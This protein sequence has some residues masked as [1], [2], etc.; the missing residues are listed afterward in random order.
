MSAAIDSKDVLPPQVD[1][2][3]NPAAVAV[4]PPAQEQPAAPEKT[5]PAPYVDPREEIAQRFQARRREVDGA[6]QFDAAYTPP[7]TVD[8]PQPD[9]GPAAQQQPAA[10]PAAAAPAAERFTV[11][12]NRNDVDLSWDEVAKASE[13]E[14][15]ELATLPRSAVLGLARKNL[16][17]LAYLDEAKQ[18][19]KQTRLPT[20]SPAPGEDGN[21]DQPAGD[22]QGAQGDDVDPLF[23]EAIEKIQYG[24]PKE[25][26]QA[27][28]QVIQTAMDVKHAEERMP[29][30]RQE[31]RT[32]LDTFATENADMARDPDLSAL[33][34]S[35][36][37]DNVRA[38]LIG[39]G[40]SEEAVQHIDTPQAA[41]NAYVA[42][43]L[44]GFNVR[45]PADLMN[46]AAT[47]VRNRFVKGAEPP[48]PQPAQPAASQQRTELKRQALQQPTRTAAPPAQPT[49]TGGEAGRSSVVEQ[50]R[51]ARGFTS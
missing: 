47:H 37:V 10:Q 21:E 35:K 43:R 7:F 14:P 9:P 27:L 24:D 22:G 3:P 34:M 28:R 23:A 51:R 36:I 41:G 31:V 20:P 38:E 25:G 29:V 15:E 26:A 42:A 49:R 1:D 44:R 18:A 50:M 33:V 5:E 12:I 4:D 32:A 40:F 13:L 2:N 30:Y 17:A 45:P 11:R 16:A 6:N 46:D 48:A 19:A 39:A 8:Q